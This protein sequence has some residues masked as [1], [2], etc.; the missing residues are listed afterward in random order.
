MKPDKELPK[1]SLVQPQEE[2][3]EPEAARDMSPTHEEMSKQF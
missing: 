1:E 3:L 2:L